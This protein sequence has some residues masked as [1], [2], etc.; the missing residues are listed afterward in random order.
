M[1]LSLPG[2][3]ADLARSADV[4]RWDCLLPLIAAEIGVTAF[5]LTPCSPSLD[6]RLIKHL[7]GQ[8][9]GK[10]DSRKVEVLF[11]QL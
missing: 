1:F 11:L 7:I 5:T 4:T 2:S 9:R 10:K 6:P 3:A 8:Q